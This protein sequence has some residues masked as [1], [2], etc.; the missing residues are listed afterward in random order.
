LVDKFLRFY[1]N[2]NICQND[3]TNLDAL[4]DVM[5]TGF[6]HRSFMFA[7]VTAIFAMLF[8]GIGIASEPIYNPI[9][10][11]V[12]DNVYAI[13]GPL[14]QRS[15]AN[16]GLNA[17]YGFVVTANGVIL[18]DSGASAHSAATLERAVKTVT[19]KPINWVLNTGVQDHRWL[20]NDYFAKNGAEIHAMAGS[21]N[22]QRASAADQLTGLR[23][24]V[25]K[26]LDGTSPG[27]ATRVHAAPEASLV[28]DGVRIQWIE[29]NAHYPGDTMIYLPD[30][31]VIFTGDLVYVDRILGVLPQSNVR[32]AHRAFKQMAALNPKYI[33]PGHGRVSNLAQ[34]Q[35]DT[36]DY[37]AFL[38]TNVG[39]AA[40]NMEPI[41][42]T[43]NKFAKPVQ[44]VHLENFAELH[45]ANM[46][47]VFIDFEVNP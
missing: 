33:V 42:E 25:G 35:K 32:K 3:K 12:S 6:N 47:R 11:K 10:Q 8:S 9:P 23:R 17:N 44:F 1:T 38:I 16:A 21:V 5:V 24:F 28:I 31:S 19:S 14:G 30:Q 4:R 20:G 46:S 26:Q 45:R 2:R 22:A 13:I 37:Y 29:T 36:G 40:R 7:F 34:A 43:I 39:A 41:G 15:E 27:Y 18:I